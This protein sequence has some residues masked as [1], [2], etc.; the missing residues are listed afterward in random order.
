M[1]TTINL[2]LLSAV[3]LSSMETKAQSTNASLST[4]T[5][6][7]RISRAGEL[8]YLLYLPPG[9]DQTSS[10]HWPLMLFLHGAGE[11]G[12]NVQSVA[13]HGPMSLVKQGTNFPFIIV[14]PQC[15]AGELWDNGPLLQLLDCIM[16]KYAVDTN[17]VYLTGLS[18]GGYGTWKLGLQQ[19]GRFAAIA[20]VCGG[21]SMIDVILGNWDKG[22]ALKSLPVWA[23]HGGRDDVVPPDESERLIKQLKKIGV[24]DVKLTI[25]PE[26]GHDSWKE[27][28]GDPKFYEWMLSQRRRPQAS[29]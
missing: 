9:Y 12:T 3:L 19:P 7:W 28:Y 4:A 11:R 25:Y 22:E 8:K 5:L 17:R 2:V 24:R 20:P 15:P 26:A 14:A 10:K 18:M 23:F 13:I 29:D 21:G 27:V 6:D 16:A 1:K